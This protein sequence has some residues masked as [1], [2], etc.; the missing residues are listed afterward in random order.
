MSK[1]SKNKVK[2]GDYTLTFSMASLCAADTEL[3]KRDKK[4]VLSVIGALVP[5]FTGGGLDAIDLDGVD[6]E[7]FAVTLWCF[8]NPAHDLDFDECLEGPLSEGTPKD[9]IAPLFQLVDA[10]TAKGKADESGNAKA[11]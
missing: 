10:N 6:F 3:K 7:T 9:W 1:F 2:V 4:S 8:L 11:A 5:A